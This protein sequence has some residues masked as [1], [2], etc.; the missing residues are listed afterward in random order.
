MVG[1]EPTFEL[2]ITELVDGSI[3]KTFALEKAVAHNDAPSKAILAMLDPEVV[4]VETL[5][6]EMVISVM[7]PDPL[8]GIYTCPLTSNS[9]PGFEATLI[10]EPTMAPVEGL[11]RSTFDDEYDVAHILVPSYARPEMPLPVRVMVR[12]TVAVVGLMSV[13]VFDPVLATKR[14]LPT[15]TK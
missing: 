9:I 11:N 10:G 15:C 1:C 14:W 8:P 4:I 5:N 12:V 6:V 3:R 2:L 7:L 13:T